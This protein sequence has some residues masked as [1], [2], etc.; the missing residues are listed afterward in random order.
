MSRAMTGVLLTCLA[1]FG[2]CSYL[3][4]AIEPAEIHKG[5]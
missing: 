1:K 4:L 3:A 5:V 2:T